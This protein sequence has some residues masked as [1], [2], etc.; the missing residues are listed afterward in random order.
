MAIVS[1]GLGDTFDEWRVKTNTVA[2]GQGD[3]TTL[4][5]THKASVVGAINELF[6]SD[7]D[8]MENLVDDTSP[9]LGGE[10]Q[11]NNNNIAGTGSINITGGGTFTGNVQAT[12]QLSSSN[13]IVSV[14][15]ADV[16]V[17]PHGTGDVLLASDIIK[18]G[19]SGT[20]TTLTTNGSG[21]LKLAPNGGGGSQPLLQLDNVGDITL[22]PPGTKNVILDGIKFPNADGSSGQYLKTDGS[23]VLSFGTITALANV[24]DDTSP[25]L[26]GDLD[27]NSNDITGTGQFAGTSIATAVTGTTHSAGDNSTKL[28]TT[29]YVD[30]G[31]A[32]AASIGL[33]I[34]LG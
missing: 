1:V 15:N 18:I 6:T 9:Q 2:T 34:A 32:S 24:L 31:D 25:Q 28:A 30:A 19:P 33:I 13:S 21:T 17:T 11:L 7:S 4:S 20:D 12:L 27:L 8:D 14:G 3:L 22:T 16:V 29:A 5:T 10:L 23:G 26:G